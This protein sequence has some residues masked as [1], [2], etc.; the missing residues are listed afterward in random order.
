MRMILTFTATLAM[1]ALAWA[2]GP[3]TPPAKKKA[4]QVKK[5]AFVAAARKS[6]P[7]AASAA[8]PVTGK[9]T[10]GSTATASAKG[11]KKPPVR[12]TTT[13]RNR[14]TTPSADR[15]KQIQDAL[16][17]KGYLPAEDA[18]GSWGQA[19]AD[20][21]K[22]FQAEQTLETTGKINSLSLIALGLGPNRRFRRHPAGGRKQLPAARSR[23][24]LA[25]LRSSSLKDDGRPPFL[26]VEW[27]KFAKSALLRHADRRSILRM[28][29]ASRTAGKPRSVPHPTRSQPTPPSVA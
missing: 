1:A 15:Y 8:K 4:Y 12:S 3:N 5:S 21:L 16:V 17:A 10:S 27:L 20:A 9:K 14:Q 6:T 24:Q 23:T 13:W 11:A 7:A 26:Y 22:N 18:T 2:G 28:N 29:D 25:S 19:S